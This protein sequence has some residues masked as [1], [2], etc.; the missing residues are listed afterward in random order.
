MQGAVLGSVVGSQSGL[1]SAYLQRSNAR[2]AVYSMRNRVS[3]YP[4]HFGSRRMSS[5]L[6]TVR[7]NCAVENSSLGGLALSSLSESLQ[8]AVVS[9]SSLISVNSIQELPTLSVIGILLLGFGLGVI[10]T[11]VSAKLSQTQRG[12]EESQMLTRRAL[13]YISS[14][15]E[16]ELEDIIGCLPAWL[17]IESSERTS[18]LNKVVT[19]AWP[20]LDSATSTVIVNALDPILQKTR[21]SFLTSIQF[22]RFSFGSV[23]A[24][25]E[26]V[27]VYDSAS[28]GALEID[29]QVFWAGDPDVVLKVRA[30]QD[31]LAVPV[32]LTEFQCTFTL[33][34]IFA[35]LI[36][37][38]P[39]FGALT[40]SL[41]DEPEVNFDLRVVGGDI[42]LVPGLSQPLRTYIR[43]LIAS[44][45]VWPRCI[46]VPIPG[47]GYSLPD[48]EQ[49]SAGLLHVE[50]H[51]H[52]ALLFSPSEI[53]LQLRWPGALNSGASQE[54]RLEALSGGNFENSREI[55][56]PVD[57]P[58]R[59]V[60]SVCWY[61]TDVLHV[62]QESSDT[63][64]LLK[65]ETTI[66][67]DDVARQL[68]KDDT[69]VHNVDWGPVTVALELEPVTIKAD[70]VVA[71]PT[72]I[73][74]LYRRVLNVARS[75]TSKTLSTGN[76]TSSI[77]TYM[78]DVSSIASETPRL[79]QLKIRYQT[80]GS[81]QLN[82]Q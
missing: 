55:T 82:K 37:V 56:L 15:E 16:D 12:K 64:K 62:P 71:T 43:A 36:G 19:A 59:Q 77:D 41:T 52:D 67:V 11:V 5:Q 70:T 78:S 28:E 26:A 69:S 7:G 3:I 57:D 40:I 21:P 66:L 50:V 58:I 65:G 24:V 47:T 72:K 49:V 61:S 35:P 33:R 18:W 53:G 81:A 44:F 79:V 42:T 51:S 32:S 27:K 29:L 25:I 30:A 46:T 54:V 63:L 31:T 68:R 74:S 1:F 23:P 4:P 13:A 38:F 60:L 73:E 6:M 34:L 10:T 39:C 76:D 8:N 48:T 2:G 45:L 9:T 22:E 17:S 20:Y 80:I 14:L 75:T